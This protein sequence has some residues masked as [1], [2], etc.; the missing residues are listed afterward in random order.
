MLERYKKLKEEELLVK[1][2]L[3]LQCKE[4]AKRGQLP[5]SVDISSSAIS[6]TS[7]LSY[8]NVSSST[9][10]KDPLSIEYSFIL[11][12]I[13]HHRYVPLPHLLF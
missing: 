1:K 9:P 8:S 11:R 12:A 13:F 10:G 7:D 4:M 3:E 2:K 6:S 5:P